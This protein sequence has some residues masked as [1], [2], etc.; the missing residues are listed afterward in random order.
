[1]PNCCQF[2]S[3]FVSSSQRLLVHARLGQLYVRSFICFGE[4]KNNFKKSKPK[5][6]QLF[7]ICEKVEQGGKIEKSSSFVL[8]ISILFFLPFSLRKYFY[9]QHLLHV[10]STCSF[11]KTFLVANVGIFLSIHYL[12]QKS[13]FKIRNLWLKKKVRTSHASPIMYRNSPLSVNDVFELLLYLCSQRVK[14]YSYY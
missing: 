10:E 4:L 5:L 11:A 12:K 2:K 3:E 8:S 13:T 6:E 1:M 14:P 7:K 9:C